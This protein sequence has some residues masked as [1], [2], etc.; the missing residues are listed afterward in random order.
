MLNSCIELHNPCTKIHN[1]F[2]FLRTLVQ[3]E[4]QNTQTRDPSRI[5]SHYKF[6]FHLI[7]T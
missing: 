1:S 4:K 7:E 5:L 6:N 2:K 3:S